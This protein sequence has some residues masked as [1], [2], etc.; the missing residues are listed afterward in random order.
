MTVN[1]VKSRDYNGRV[2]ETVRLHTELYNRV[3][4]VAKER[5]VS[6]SNLMAEILE[7]DLLMSR[8]ANRVS[9][10]VCKYCDQ[11][12]LLLEDDNKNV[13]FSIPLPDEAWEHFF[14]TFYT[15]KADRDKKLGLK[16]NG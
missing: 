1:L 8:E 14:K 15:V 3:R 7:R 5:G 13:E 9:I 16:A 4:S 10:F 6:A 2:P 12:H 11:I